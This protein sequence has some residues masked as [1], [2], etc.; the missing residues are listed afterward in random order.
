ME[1]II[2][3]LVPFVIILGYMLSK[4]KK[5]KEPARPKAPTKSKK[6][7]F[8]IVG[9]LNKM[10]EEYYE[11]DADPATRKS[12]TEGSQSWV[13]ESDG[14]HSYS[15]EEEDYYDDED[16]EEPEGEEEKAV[17]EGQTDDKDIPKR[18]TEPAGEPPA[19]AAHQ[20]DSTASP[21]LK[22]SSYTPAN[23]G[24][25]DLRKAVVWSEILG[26]PVALRDE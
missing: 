4:L 12:R 18:E 15:T 7:D 11:S 13:D 10:L 23:I 5:K 8:T 19:P 14:A 2:E 21:M 1:N 25:R 26:K 17:V 16:D 9:K 24:K 22:K 3:Y 20:I 6:S